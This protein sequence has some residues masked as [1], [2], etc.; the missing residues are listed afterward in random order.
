[1]YGIFETIVINL[2]FS[3]AILQKITESGFK[4][5]MQKEVTLTTEQAEDFYSEHRDQE[6]F[7]PL[8]K[9]MTWWV[10]IIPVEVVV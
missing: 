6:Y 4:I 8:V 5:A 7:A 10:G 1:M 3:D 9:Q 2:K